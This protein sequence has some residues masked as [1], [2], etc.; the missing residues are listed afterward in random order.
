MTLLSFIVLG[1]LA[2]LNQ[3]QRAFKVGMSQEEV[4]NLDFDESWDN[5]NAVFFTVGRFHVLRYPAAWSLPIAVLTVWARNTVLDTDQYVATVAPLAED[6]DNTATTMGFRGGEII[7]AT[8][9]EQNGVDV[10]AI[11]EPHDPGDQA[12]RGALRRG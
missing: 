5:S 4:G 11:R 10:G 2:V 8:L 9:G 3:T 7:S 12:D 6:E 1:L